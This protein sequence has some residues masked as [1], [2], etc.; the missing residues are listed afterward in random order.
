MPTR[1]P[2]RMSAS[3]CSITSSANPTRHSSHRQ[4]RPRGSSGGSRSRCTT[5]P[6]VAA[7]TNTAVRRDLDHW[8]EQIG[9]RPS[10]LG[11]FEDP[12][13]MKAFGAEAGAVFAAPFAIARDVCRVY[14]VRLV[15]RTD[16]VKERY[17]R[18]RR[19]DA[20]RTQASWRSPPP[21][22][23]GCSR[24]HQ[25]RGAAAATLRDV[26]SLG[27]ALLEERDLAGLDRI[28]AADHAYPAFLKQP[29]Q[30]RAAVENRPQLVPRVLHGD[31]LD[32]R[33]R[34]E[35]PSARRLDVVNGRPRSCRAAPSGVPVRRDCRRP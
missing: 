17:T 21:R 31:L 8:F 14:G 22:G 29:L 27:E 12:A 26:A 34:C 20:S 19:S 11:E 9:I 1:R 5:T 24:R 15:G 32:E 13:L 25:P 2:L 30:D 3:G 4:P 35:V 18:S 7:T 28:D 6:M 10:I 23:T 16:S 33:L